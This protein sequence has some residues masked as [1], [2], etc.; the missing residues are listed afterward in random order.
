[1]G[2]PM[3][4]LAQFT[5]DVPVIK[6]TS[7]ILLLSEK[8][9]AEYSK[10]VDNPCIRCGRC[11]NTCPVGMLPYALSLC[12]EMDNIAKASEHNPFDCIE[13]GTCT[14]VCPA[15]RRILEAIRFIKAVTK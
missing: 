3:M 4:G 10:Q 5:A 15:K 12:F 13:C 2:G 8:E 1:M 6:G 7:G 9:V 14:Y 11:V